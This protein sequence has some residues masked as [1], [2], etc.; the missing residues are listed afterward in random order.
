MSLRER[1]RLVVMRHLSENILS[2]EDA[3]KAMG[4]SYR[5]ARRVAQR[6]RASGDSGLVHASRGRLGNHR[7]P[8]AFREEVL[9]L[10]RGHLPNYGPTLAS[11]VLKEDF[12]VEVCPE[13]LRRWLH[14]ECLIVPRALALKHRRRRPRRE[15][16]GEM[17]QMDGSAHAWFKE[18]APACNLMVA[19]DDATGRTLCFFSV[20]ETLLS[21][22]ELLHQWI[23]HHGVPESLYVDRRTIYEAN[24]EPFGWEKRLGTGA[25]TDFGH[26]CRA[27]WIRLIRA[28]SP[29]GKGRVERKNQDLQDRLVK[30]LE[31]KGISSICEANAYLPEYLEGFNARFSRPAASAVDRHRQRPDAQHLNELLCRQEERTVQND[32]TLSVGGRTYQI[33]DKDCPARQKVMVRRH[34]D[35]TVSILREGRRLHFHEVAY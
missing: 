26:A 6:Y 23:V 7:L 2:L 25:M 8:G 20:Q 15:C 1:D 27:L 9:R 12:G 24:R 29:Q 17:L 4:L 3:A 16:F 22:Y 10:Y 34:L 21:A 18:R 32:W 31:R 33:V 19:V 5:H 13:T 28:R 30:A 35:N 14:A 11:E